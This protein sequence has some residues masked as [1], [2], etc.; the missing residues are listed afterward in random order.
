MRT[1]TDSLS[2]RKVTW[3]SS[4]FL[5]GSRDCV[6]TL[7]ERFLPRKRSGLAARPRADRFGSPRQGRRP[8]VPPRTLFS[9]KSIRVRA[10]TKGPGKDGGSR[11]RE[12]AR[13][14]E[15]EIPNGI[16]PIATGVGGAATCRPAGE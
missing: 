9:F 7:I 2:G 5:E 14:M 1:L 15:S 8:L 3:T 13:R 4:S 12:R 10:D 6:C 11:D 16:I